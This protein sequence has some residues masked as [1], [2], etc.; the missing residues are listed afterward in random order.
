MRAEPGPDHD[1]S[2]EAPLPALRKHR[3]IRRTVFLTEEEDQMLASNTR[4]R[5]VPSGAEYL[6]ML[7]EKDSRGELLIFDEAIGNIA[8]MVGESIGGVLGRMAREADRVLW[9]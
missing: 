4:R 5:Y 8:R 9:S 1:D 7:I 3:P 6:R 2:T